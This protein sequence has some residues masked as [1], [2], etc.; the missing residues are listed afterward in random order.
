M[1][2]KIGGKKI[3]RS[4]KLTALLM[5]T[6][7]CATALFG[8]GS[9]DKSA[10]TANGTS[11]D[12]TTEEEKITCTL[13]VWGP[14]N[15]QAE[16]K[17]AWLQTMCEQFNAE[18]PNWDITFEYGTCSEGDAGKN[19]SQDPSAAADVYMFAT[20][21]IKTL[22]EASAISQLGGDTATYIQNTNSEAMVDAVTYDGK[23]YGVPFTTNLFYMYY[24]KS[25]FSEEDVKSLD[26][27]LEKGTVAFEI[28][29]SWHIQAFFLA[30][31]CSF[32]ENTID[33]GGEK[34]VEA[35]TYLVNAVKSGKLKQGGVALLQDGQVNAAFSGSWDA[36]NAKEFL[37]DNYAAAA[38][39]S[40]ESENGDGVLRTMAS[41][42]AIGVNPNT[43]YP[44]VAVALAKYLGGE[45]AQKAHYDLLGV[46]PCNTALLED[47]AF[48]NDPVAIA[49][50]AAFDNTSIIQPN[51]LTNECYW[52]PASD[53]GKAIT[54]GTVTLD[55][56][57]EQV[58]LF[59]EQ[60][61]NA[62][63]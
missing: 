39:P 31:G 6:A 1:R 58:E 62:I 60:M 29:N 11:S 36:G 49:Q 46:V 9:D 21:Q 5:T 50:N 27:M 32:G 13:K 38:L 3:M 20:D 56:V 18:H 34:G 15:E 48:Q 42:K 44:Q 10:T 25:V 35:A 28:E 61:N 2:L 59:N 55:N 63:Q 33:F 52:T 41:A 30:T 47:E 37:G 16:D 26:T 4:R 22:V 19:V 53:F 40:I 45:E 24:D 43:Q 8:C 17:G 54:G 51:W 14:E 12:A 57:A 7:L 23:I